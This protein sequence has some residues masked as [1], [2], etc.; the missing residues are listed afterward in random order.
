[1]GLRMFT[2]EVRSDVLWESPACYNFDAVEALRVTDAIVDRLGKFYAGIA[3]IM[4]ISNE[5]KCP[6]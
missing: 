2:W 5:S 1:M 6:Q 4:A 3:L